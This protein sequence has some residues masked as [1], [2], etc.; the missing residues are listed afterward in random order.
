MDRL[1]PPFI[2][3]ANWLSHIIEKRGLPL[4]VYETW[5][6][7]ETQEKYFKR[8]VTKA[9]AGQSPH[10]H[11]LAIDF[12]LDTAKINVR[13]REWR[14]KLYP[15]AWD[16]ETPGAVDV[17]SELGEIA[18]DLGLTWGGLWIHKNA[19]PKRKTSGELIVLGW[20]LP[21]IEL[22]NWKSYR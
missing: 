4:T 14:G 18:K 5:R 17:W 1:S 15:D 7:A 13:K 10:N 6:S 9:R 21:H 12:V 19:T 22:T 3:A 20:D 16:D 2:H 11:G 8:K